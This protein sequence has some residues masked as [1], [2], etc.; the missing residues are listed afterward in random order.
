MMW[1]GEKFSGSNLNWSGFTAWT[2]LD[3]EMIVV[4]AQLTDYS[5]P[6]SLFLLDYLAVMGLFVGNGYGLSRISTPSRA[7]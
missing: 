3:T 4:S 7:Q 2:K 6:L 1:F 5:E